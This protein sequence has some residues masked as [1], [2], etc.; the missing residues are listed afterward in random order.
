MKC[1]SKMAQSSLAT[2]VSALKAKHKVRGRTAAQLSGHTSA[3]SPNE[4]A[5]HWVRCVRGTGLALRRELWSAR[6]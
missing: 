3:H 1:E 6:A 2:V 4:S 5:L